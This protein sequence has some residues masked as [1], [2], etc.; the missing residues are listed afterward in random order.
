[1]RQPENTLKL[2]VEFLQDDVEGLAADVIDLDEELD[3]VVETIRDNFETIN[4]NFARIRDAHNAL[5]ENVD[6]HHECIKELTECAENLN[7]SLSL[8]TDLLKHHESEI[9]KLKRWATGSCI[10]IIL[11]AIAI[12]LKSVGL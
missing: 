8:V 5:K 1:M 11:L 9:K 2:D 3:G 10:C 6:I 12:I 7:N 4:G